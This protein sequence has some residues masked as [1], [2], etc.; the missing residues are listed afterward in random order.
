MSNETIK[1]LEEGVGISQLSVE[2]V[3]R[4]KVVGRIVNAYERFDRE[5]RERG[6]NP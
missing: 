2:D 3:V 1:Q 5:Q 6:Q 4:H